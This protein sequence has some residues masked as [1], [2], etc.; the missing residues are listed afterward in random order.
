VERAR[1]SFSKPH[2]VSEDGARP[3]SADLGGSSSYSNEVFTRRPPSK[4]GGGLI[5]CFED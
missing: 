4:E 1:K 2:C 3:P 5:W